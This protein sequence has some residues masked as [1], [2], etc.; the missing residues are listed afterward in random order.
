MVQ[1]L[2]D[3]GGYFTYLTDARQRGA[4]IEII[5]GDGR[6]SLDREPPQKFDLLVL[7]AFSGDSIPAH[8]LDP[9]AFV[10][11]RKH[12]A[13]NGVI[14]VHITNSYLYLAPVVRGL[15]KDSDLGMTRIYSLHDNKLD[16]LRNDWMLLSKDEKVLAALPSMAP[17]DEKD[18]F[19]IPLWTDH[20]NN[21]FKILK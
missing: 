9:E 1:Q 4:K 16:L 5:M 8:L 10:I 14:A 13:P 17:P 11:Y 7:D 3:D 15:A 2:A 18:D 6:L 21:L 12:M 19:E 20:Y